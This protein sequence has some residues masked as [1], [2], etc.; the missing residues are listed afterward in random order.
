MGEAIFCLRGGRK[1]RI[2]NEMSPQESEHFFS[3]MLDGG[4][5][6]TATIHVTDGSVVVVRTTDIMW[7]ELSADDP[8]PTEARSD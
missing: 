8:A 7:V 4:A 6:Y 2:H 1:I 5:L 3:D